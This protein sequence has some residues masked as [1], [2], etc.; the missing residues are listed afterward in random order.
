MF[1]IMGESLLPDELAMFTV[2]TKRPSAP[3]EPVREFTGVIG[4]RGGKSRAL[5]VLAAYFATCVDHRSIAAICD[6]RAFWRSDE[7]SANPDIEIIRALKPTLL[8]TKGPLISISSPYARRGY[9]WNTYQKHFGAAGNPRILVAQGAS[10]VM[11]P[12]VDMDWIAQQFEEDPAGAEAEYNAQFRTDVE[13]FIDRD[14]VE[15]CVES[16]CFEI[17][18][19]GKLYYGFVDASGGSGGDSMTMAVSHMEGD[20]AVLNCIR[21]RRPPFSPSEVCEEFS[22]A[23]KSYGLARVTADHWGTGFVKEGFLRTWDRVPSEC[24]AEI[25]FVS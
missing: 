22:A 8:I 23:F 17:P 7:L 20:I 15:S 18:P 19:C 11:N 4:R 12:C 21:E 25:R 14:V 2:L 6:E 10:Q 13:S 1:A 9:L 3:V 16:G 24:E 5:G